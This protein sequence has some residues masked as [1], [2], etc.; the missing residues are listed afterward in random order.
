MSSP[1]ASPLDLAGTTGVVTGASGFIGRAVLRQLPST[2]T[3]Y[4]TYNSASDFPAWAEDCDADVRPLRIDL[5]H[6]RLAPRV[7]DAD[8]ALLM[9]ARVQTARSWADPMSELE[10]V[11]GVCVNSVIGLRARRVVLLS[12]GSVYE[13]LDGALHPG[14]VLAPK[15]PYSIAKLA[16]ELLFSAYVDAPYWI[17]R[18]FG[19]FGPGEPPFKLARRL[20]EAFAGGESTFTLSGDGTNRIDAM[21]ITEA[22]ARLCSIL[23][24]EPESRI[25]DLSH[26]DAL[27]LRRFVEIAFESSHPAPQETPL[28]LRLSGRA[29][30]LM[31]G[32]AHSD[33]AIWRSD[34][35][36]VPTGDA[37]RR[38]ARHLLTR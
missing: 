38:Y 37:F 23:E 10:S 17:V 32:C 22:A 26:G 15:L 21:Y 7:P 35:E 14:R 27:T 2:C 20:V 30:E 8:W 24:T 4:A 18:F 36:H 19:A 12:S 9:A 6:E 3:V 16:A 5:R 1:R 28:A 33:P 29:H 13:S 25:V 11:A 31:L 34:L